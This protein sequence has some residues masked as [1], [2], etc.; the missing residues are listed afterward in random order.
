MKL[1]LKSK[2][3]LKLKYYV[4]AI[5]GEISGLGKINIDKDQNIIVEDVRIFKQKITGSTTD[6]D[7]KDIA[8]FYFELQKNGQAVK[9]WNLWW[10]SHDNMGVFWS[11]KDDSTIEEHAGGGP[12]LV[13][14]VTNKKDEYKARLDIYPKDTSPFKKE[15]FCTYDLDVDFYSSPKIEKEKTK[16]ES[17]IDE[18]NEELGKISVNYLNIIEKAEEKLKQLTEMEVED[19]PKIKKLCEKHVKEN[20][21]KEKPFTPNFLNM[22]YYNK[23]NHHQKKKHKE[24]GYNYWD[25]P[26]YYAK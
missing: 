9:D 26:K 21:V 17:L 5:D 22:G 8:K 12:F 3:S 19:N 1:I 20:V 23:F 10:H 4:N 24:I 7:S 25:D 13:S 15:S 11:T 14:L 18:A 2:A 6:I 16:L